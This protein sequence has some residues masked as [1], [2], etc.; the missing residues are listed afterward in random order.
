[1]SPVR[2]VPI[3]SSALRSMVGPSITYWV[4]GEPDPRSDATDA[5]VVPL[6]ARIRDPLWFL[7]RQWQLGEFQGADSGSPAYAALSE[8]SGQLTGWSVGGATA[9]PLGSAPLE[10]QTEREPFSPD[11]ATRV[12]LGQ[13]FEQLLT[14]AGQ[15]ALVAAFRA[16]YPIASTPV[17]PSDEAEVRFRSVVGAR[18]IDGIAL[19]AAAAAA[20]PALPATPTVPAAAQSLVSSALGALAKWIANTIGAVGTTD[21]AAWTA[22][23]LECALTVSGTAP[24]GQPVALS[25]APGA[26]GLLDWSALD[27]TGPLAGPQTVVATTRAII[28]THV[29]FRGAPNAR[30]WDFEAAGTDLGSIVP[31]KRDLARLALMDF[32]MLHSNDWFV[33][34]IDMAPGALHQIDQLLVHDVFGVATLVGRSDREAG[35]V[36]QWSMFTTSVANQPPSATADFFVLSPSAASAIQSGSVA[37]EVEFARDEIANMVWALEQTTENALGTAWPGHERDVARNVPAPGAAPP[38]PP[39]LPGV[40]LRYQIESGIPEHWIPF[41]PVSV[42][43]AAGSV[44]LERAAMLRDDGTPIE[45]AGRILRPSSIPAGTPYRVP[46]EEI[47]RTGVVVQRVISRCRWVDGSTTLWMMRRRGPGTG[48]VNSALR[49]DE[50][51]LAP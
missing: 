8:R 13:T 28:P 43:A 1:M 21:P 35:S 33:V 18:A 5:L 41:L 24:T 50:A 20:A 39:T 42:D 19:A 6:E 44:A 14:D 46:E 3:V 31:D 4:R 32:V 11:V 40:P 36:G 29:R 10:P 23:R 9:A 16:A 47:A 2:D 51:L 26:D 27:L 45:P 30:F 48:E 37:E 12:E 7:T 49:F 38:A 17:D 15:S 22:D 34:P 25:A